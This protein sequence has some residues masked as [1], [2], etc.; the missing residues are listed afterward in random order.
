MRSSAVRATTLTLWAATATAGGSVPEGGWS[1]P[2]RYCDAELATQCPTPRFMLRIDPSRIVSGTL[3][4]IPFESSL[5]TSI[6]RGP[7]HTARMSRPACPA[8]DADRRMLVLLVT[9]M[10]QEAIDGDF[11][12]KRSP[13]FDIGMHAGEFSLRPTRGAASGASAAR[14]RSQSASR[15]KVEILRDAPWWTISAHQHQ[16]CRTPSLLDMPAD[17]DR[18]LGAAGTARSAHA[19]IIVRCTVCCLARR[20]RRSWRRCPA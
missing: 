6:E 11:Q 9:R 4:G 10:S 12:P 8:T 13:G 15:R 1:G 2:G 17:R 14:G 3:D 16:P 20:R 7:I 5:P 18:S 19:F